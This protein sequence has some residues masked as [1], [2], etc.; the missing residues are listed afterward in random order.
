MVAAGYLAE[1]A[2]TMGY[3][4]SRGFLH[5]D[6]KPSNILV[7]PPVGLRVTD[8]GLVKPIHSRSELTGEG[9]IVGTPSYMAPEQSLSNANASPASDVYSL[10][11]ILYALLTGVPPFSA[12]NDVDTLIQVR[13]KDRI[14]PKSIN[15]KV[16]SDLELVCLKCLAKE[17]ERRTRRP[18]Y[19]PKT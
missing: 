2:K 17:P 3:A 7:D 12:E 4:H 16:P 11:A 8:F 14:P 13:T 15:G 10:G 1:I 9:E 18:T 6:L 19:W 5:R